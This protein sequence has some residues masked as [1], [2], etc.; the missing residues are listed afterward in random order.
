[1]KSHNYFVY[2]TTNP[3]RTVLYTG[4]TNNLERRMSEHLQDSVETRKSFAGKY[5]C[6]NLIYYE[7][8]SDIRVAIS[9]EKYIKRLDRWKK[10]ELIV[11][12]NPG[13]RFL[14]DSSELIKGNIPIW[15]SDMEDKRPW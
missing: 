12:F 2:I 13:W 10:E 7:W 9:R 4:V 5:F 1:M 8:Y 3:R 14:N 6:Y 11:F 15:S